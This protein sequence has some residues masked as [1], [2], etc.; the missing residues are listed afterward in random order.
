MIPDPSSAY[1]VTAGTSATPVRLVVMLYEQLIKD[2]QRALS[3]IQKRDIET[4]SR[5]LSHAL[6]VL[7]QLQGTIN[8]QNGGDVAGNLDR[9]YFLL[10]AD[11]VEAQFKVAPHLLQKHLKSLIDLR[12]AWLQVERAES[13]AVHPAAPVQPVA[14]DTLRK[15]SS[16]RV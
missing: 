15:T 6:V 11:L 1:R 2:L 3:A 4:R 5:E 10:R 16:W 12:E 7:G 8:H 14:P 13:S 9:F